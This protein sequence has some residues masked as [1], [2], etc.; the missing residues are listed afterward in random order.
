VAAAAPP[1]RMAALQAEAAQARLPV[2]AFVVRRQVSV[3]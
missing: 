1:G 2:A 3:A